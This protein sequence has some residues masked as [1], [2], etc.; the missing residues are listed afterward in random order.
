MAS[1]FLHFVDT[2]DASDEFLDFLER[3]PEAQKAA[4]LV[5]EVQAEALLQMIEDIKDGV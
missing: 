2:G 4:D 5:F 3:S 1:E